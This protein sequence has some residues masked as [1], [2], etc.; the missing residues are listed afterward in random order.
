M[1]HEPTYI[2]GIDPGTTTGLAIYRDGELIRLLGKPFWEVYDIVARADA[3]L[4]L[5]IE[6]ARS[7]PRFAKN[8]HTSGGIEAHV[9]VG[10][11]IGVTDAHAALWETL[12]IHLGIPYLLRQPSGAKWDADDLKTRTG[13]AHPTNQHSR[14]AARIAYRITHASSFIYPKQTP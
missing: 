11:S 12:A 4:A 1:K 13:W 8:R 10:R 2:V 7:M 14:D 3:D 6:D 9:A 5:V